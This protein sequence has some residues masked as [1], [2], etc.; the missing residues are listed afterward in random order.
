[1]WT[2]F[3][4]AGGV[5]YHNDAKAFQVEHM[6]LAKREDMMERKF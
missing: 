3:G 2:P 4:N 5:Y 1:M 6:E